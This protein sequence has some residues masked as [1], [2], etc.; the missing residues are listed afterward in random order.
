LGED[1]GVV[2]RIGPDEHRRHVA[3]DDGQRRH[4]A[5]HG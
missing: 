2:E 4:P 1:D 5:L 3:R